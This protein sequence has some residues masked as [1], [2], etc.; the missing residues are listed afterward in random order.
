MKKRVLIV[1]IAL[2]AILL[3]MSAAFADS[4]GMVRV[5]LTRLGSPSKLVFTADCDY[6]INND[7]SLKIPSG[8][9]ITVTADDGIISVETEGKLKSYQTSFTLNRIKGGKSGAK[10]TSPALAN[11]FT[12]DFTFKSSKGVIT[13]IM[14]TYVEDYLAGVVAYE[15]SNSYP[16]SAL[17]A[18]AVAA[19][20]Y[21]LRAKSA[22]TQKDYDVVDNAN[23]QVYKGYNPKYTKV[24]TAI[25]TTKGKV[26]M[27]DGKFAAC[28]YGGSNGGQTEASKN[29]WGGKGLPYS[30]V[31]DDPYDLESGATFRRAVLKKDQTGVEMNSELRECLIEGIKDVLTEYN[32]STDPSDIKINSIISIAPQNPKYASPSILYQELLFTVSATSLNNDGEE[33]TGKASV[34]IETYDNFEK[35]FNLSINKSS[36]ETI[37]V[38]EDDENFYVTFRRWGHGIGMS[39]RGAKVMAEKYGFKYTQILDFYYPGTTLSQLSLVD[40]TGSKLPHG[41]DDWE[42]PISQAVVKPKESGGKVTMRK[43]PNSS[44]EAVAKLSD[45]DKVDVYFYIGTWAAV[46]KDGMQGYVKSTYLN[47]VN[48]TPEPTVAPTPEPTK[49]P[50]KDVYARIK[51]ANKNAKLNVRAKASKNSRVVA[52][53]KHNKLVKVLATKGKWAKIQLSSGKKGYVYKKYLKK[54]ESVASVTAMDDPL[55]MT[56][57][58][59]E[60]GYIYADPD[61]DSEQIAPLSPGDEMIVLETGDGFACVSMRDYEGYVPLAIL[62][63]GD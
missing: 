18:Q 12:G 61:I 63:L 62:V 43:E 44:S 55:D 22:R 58:V 28:Y 37:M 2:I 51:L 48:D 56:G 54:V 21:V 32:L 30:I 29:P 38:T 17:K 4:D 50:D 57:L 34:V 16:G 5:K 27:Y 33:V 1:L 47:N 19:R 23:D 49:K 11:T 13:T 60:D 31:K 26:L 9:Q 42:T 35:W 15:M 45:G 53:A 46:K 8:A 36:N 41:D 39:Q 3:C 40:T 24:L 14:T 25:E 20:N 59:L 52:K 6:Y 7:A 10:F